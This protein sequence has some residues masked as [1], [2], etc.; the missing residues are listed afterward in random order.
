MWCTS[1]YVF[2]PLFSKLICFVLFCDDV[3][4]FRFIMLF[5]SY[6][7]ILLLLSHENRVLNITL[8]VFFKV[9]ITLIIVIVD[10]IHSV[11]H[12]FFTGI[13]GITRSS[14]LQ[15]WKLTYLDKWQMMNQNL[16]SLRPTP[17]GIID[18]MWHQDPS[19]PPVAPQIQ[20]SVIMG[21]L[22]MMCLRSQV[23]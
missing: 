1:F 4:W 15:F 2:H 8:F 3:V 22:A 13:T 9:K 23:F 10:Y 7:F 11:N 14:G 12:T 16:Y 20:V 17:P 5:P 18:P 21:V 6:A 19:L